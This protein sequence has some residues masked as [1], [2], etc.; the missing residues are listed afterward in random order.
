MIKTTCKI[1]KTSQ[2]TVVKDTSYL[3]FSNVNSI[4]ISH[5]KFC[6]DFKINFV[7]KCLFEQMLKFRETEQW[8]L[9]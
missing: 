7:Q 6:S 9:K 3:K 1:D 4:F 2:N 8:I 5:L